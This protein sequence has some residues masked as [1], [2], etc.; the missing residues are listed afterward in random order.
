MHQLAEKLNAVLDCTCVGG[1]LSDYGRRMYVP[2]GI[3]VQ[4]AEAKKQASRFNATIGVALEEGTAMCLSSVR[5]FFSPSLK[6]G[7]IFP[8]APMGGVPALRT[9]W[10]E[11]MYEKNPS[12]KWTS[13]SLPVVTAGLTNALSLVCSLFVDEGDSV[14]LPKMYWENYDLILDEQRQAKKVLFDNFSMD[15]NG[16]V[17]FNVSGLDEALATTGDKAVVI[18]NFPNNPTGYTPTNEEAL[19]IVEVLKRYSNSGKKLAVITD[20][21]YFGLFFDASVC[22]ESLFSRLCNCSENLLA[23][24]CDAATKEE[25]VW[26]FRVAFITYGCKGFTE[27]QYDALVQ[28]TMG[29]LRGTLSC[30]STSA[31]NILV[32]GMEDPS[33]YEEKS[34]A[35]EKIRL[36]YDALRTSLSKYAERKDL[37]PLPFNSGYFMSFECSCN[38]DELRHLLLEKYGT[39]VIR[40]DDHHIRLAF[41]SVDLKDIPALVDTIYAAAAELK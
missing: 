1:L 8:Y 13:V 14:V 29:A 25:M 5:E 12:M 24:K 22:R 4:S 33:Y 6:V 41:S 10:K 3:I 15:G 16:F 34:A 9:L 30:C 2:K 23:V 38:A 11:R 28:K 7:E 32:K 37:I 20:D 18:L 26:G 17:G 27:E 35:V 21:A 39:G 19:E 40:L 36:R 31:Q